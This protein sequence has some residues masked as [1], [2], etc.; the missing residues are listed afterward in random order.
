MADE[1]LRQEKHGKQAGKPMKENTKQKINDSTSKKS[2]EKTKE[3]KENSSES[4]EKTE[5]NAEGRK[6]EK[7]DGKKIKAPKKT[8]VSVHGR[9]L[10]ISLK[11]SKGIARFIRGKKIED[12]ISDLEAVVK[13]KKAVPMIGEM[14]HKRGT[15]GTGKYPVKASENFIRLLKSLTANGINHGMDLEKTRITMTVPN[16]APEQI[17]RFGRTKFKR[18]HVK[19]VAK[20]RGK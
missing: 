19:I 13:K 4:H 7:K 2:D 16:K 5:S 1:Q 15:H 12:A 3:I 10:P 14:A 6:E 18:T 9:S 20:E 11:H 8:E 17:H